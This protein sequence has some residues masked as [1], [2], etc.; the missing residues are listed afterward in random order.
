[1]LAVSRMWWASAA[2][3]SL[4]SAA[5]ADPTT[6]VVSGG[7]ATVA[8]PVRI[9]AVAESALTRPVTGTGTLGAKDELGLSFKVAGV[10]ARVLVDAGDRVHR[11][12]VLAALERRE[13]DA[14]VA[15]AQ[16]A[17]EKAARDVARFERLYND[18]VVTLVQLQDSRTAWSAARADLDAAA[19]NQR[20]ATIVAP[21][22]GTVLT[23]K[24]NAGEL[25]S[26]GTTVLTLAS[27]A[28][29]AVVRVGLPDR[30]V[31]QVQVANPAVVR[32][33]A[34]PDRVFVGRVTEIAAAATPG[35]GTYPVEITLPGA[36]TLPNG[37]V[38]RV[39]IRS[40]NARPVDVVPIEAIVEADG[41]RGTVYV[42]AGDGRH[43]ERREVRIAFTDGRRVGIAEGLRGAQAVVTEGA[44]Y[45]N[46]RDPVR[47]LP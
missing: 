9:A 46:D 1:M 41:G 7:K 40:A 36:D 19:F 42:L 44:P 8:R 5:C 35:T 32:F 20:Y 12:Q 6:R 2:A 38:G 25:V 30:D 13:I 43:T 16:S 4:M 39:E 47:V 29:G 24:A 26:S 14:S 21:A 37:L 17:E 34:Y 10:V 11:G 23:R 3:L 31:V 18:S 27:S 33:D 28:R 15:K 45:L 22:A